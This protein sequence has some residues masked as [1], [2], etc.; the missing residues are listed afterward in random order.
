MILI[1]TR[2]R[3]T[4][5]ILLMALLP[6]VAWDQT[7]PAPPPSDQLAA[8]GHPG[9]VVDAQTGC[10]VWN[11]NPPSGVVMT[12]S[13]PCS[14]DGRATGRGSAEYRWAVEGQ[15]KIDRYE[16]EHRDGK[17]YGQGVYTFANGNRYEGEFRDGKY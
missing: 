6:T 1:V 4:A 7:R 12:W 9:W 17:K 13:G 5:S 8:P 11:S 14:A 10:W 3:R 15:A 16:G 2:A